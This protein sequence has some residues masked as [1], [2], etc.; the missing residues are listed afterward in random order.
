MGAEMNKVDILDNKTL[1]LTVGLPYSGKSTWTRRMTSPIVCP[2]SIRVALHGNRFIKET[3]DYVWA[4]AKTMVRSLFYSSHETVIVD[5]TNITRY[6]RAKWR[7]LGNWTTTIALFEEE[8]SVCIERALDNNDSEI[9][10]IIE[11]MSEKYQPPSEDELIGMQ[12]G[13]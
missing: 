7:E 6:E 2:D 9:I 4:I 8:L 1:I 10:P 11:K 12:F 3:E 13:R 5:A